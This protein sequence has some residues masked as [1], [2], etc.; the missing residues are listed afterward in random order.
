MQCV[1]GTAAVAELERQNHVRDSLAGWHHDSTP[2]MKGAVKLCMRVS[3]A[4]GGNAGSAAK[5]TEA[6]GRHLRC[7][8]RSWVSQGSI[9]R[10]MA[11]TR[12]SN[13]SN[14]ASS[15]CAEILVDQ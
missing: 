11:L 6:H 3:D 10:N 14:S 13:S 15:H 12:Q 5:L 1:C 4:I 7:S 8:I 9:D 2:D